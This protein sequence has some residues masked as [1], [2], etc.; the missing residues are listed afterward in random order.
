MTEFA[1]KLPIH[2]QDHDEPF[3]TFFDLALVAESAGFSTLYVVD[4][5][6]LPPSRLGG[7]TTADTS[8]PFFMD[9]WMSLAALA[10]RTTRIRIGPQ[11]T[12]IGLRN[13]VFI[14]KWGATVDRISNGRLRLGV[15][16]GHQEIEYVSYGLPY[17]PFKER[18]DAMM[19]GVE[20]IRRLWTEETPVT[21]EGTYY[22]VRDVSF[23]PKPVQKPVQIWFGGTSKAIQRA[24]AKY[25]DGWFP[26][27]PQHSGFSPEFYREALDTIREQARALGR[28]EHIGSGVLMLTAISEDPAEL[29]R[30]AGLLRN[31]PEFSQ[32]SIKDLRDQGV[33]FMGDPDEICRQLE[34]YVK[35]GIE[36]ITIALHPLNDIDGIRRA[37][38][39]YSRKV[40]PNFQ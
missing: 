30:G 22:Q 9:A 35:A 7:R 13:P 32:L 6:L 19:E 20:I 38:D 10:A 8:K 1:F 40:L 5:M 11:V 17:P 26:A 37:L 18:Y 2:G 39:L 21:F 29:E 36:E 25:A 12:P 27:F 34:P 31:R 3:E 24:V 14:A 23:W 15:G 28:T 33:I 16:L 4:H